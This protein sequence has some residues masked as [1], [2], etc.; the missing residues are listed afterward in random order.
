VLGVLTPLRSGVKRGGRPPKSA[1]DGGRMADAK[2]SFAV[3]E[4]RLTTR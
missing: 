2:A 1:R 4:A 3:A